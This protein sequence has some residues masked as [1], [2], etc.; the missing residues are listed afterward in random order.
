MLKNQR[1]ICNFEGRMSNDIYPESK[2]TKT[3][4]CSFCGKALGKE[5]FFVCHICG[6]K[7]CYTHMYRHGR[8]HKSQ[9][10]E[11]PL[12]TKQVTE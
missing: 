9:P 1:P 2:T 6:A 11:T 10:K 3:A 4:S 7:Y 5:Y 12:V 8:A